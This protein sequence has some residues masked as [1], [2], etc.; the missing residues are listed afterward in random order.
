MK[1][2]NHKLMSSNFTRDDFKTLENFFKKANENTILTQ[3]PKVL[4]LRRSGQNGL[5]KYSTFLNSGSSANLISLKILK[6]ISKKKNEVI[7]PTHTWVS[8]IA[9]IIQ[10]G[11]K[12]VFVD[13]DFFHLGPMNDQIIS[14]INNKTA[15]V[16]LSH[17]QG[18]NALS[19][20]LY[21]IFKKKKNSTYRRCLRVHGAKFKNKKLGSFGLMSNFSFYYAHH[22]STIEEE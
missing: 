8:D 6:I 19:T 22:M 14:K 16:F 11:L 3:G 5:V 2:I 1:K 15:A 7:V 17:I 12:P 21:N 18:F 4:N 20:K 10:V 13:M 9:S